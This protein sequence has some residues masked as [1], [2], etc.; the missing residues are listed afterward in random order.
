MTKFLIYGAIV[1]ILIGLLFLLICYFTPE[2]KTDEYTLTIYTISFAFGSGY[3]LII[4]KIKD[5]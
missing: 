2:L 3:M 5:E 1:Y 4:N